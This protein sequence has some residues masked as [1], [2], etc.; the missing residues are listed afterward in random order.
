MSV[1]SD[2][3]GDLPNPLGEPQVDAP[4]HIPVLRSQ[5]DALDTA[6]VRLIRERARLSGRIQ[7]ARIAAGGV[8]VELGRERIVLDSYRKGLGENGTGLADAVLRACRGP[9]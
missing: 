5:I 8:R 2:L 3:I 4:E 1:S 7:A 9:L 6:I